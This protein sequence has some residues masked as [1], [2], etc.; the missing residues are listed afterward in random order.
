MRE[1]EPPFRVYACM[2][3]YDSKLE[4]PI[5][6]PK[7]I[8]DI[9]PEVSGQCRSHAVPLAETENTAHVTYFFNGGR[10]EPF[11]GEE[12]TMIPSP[13]DVATY[14][15]KPDGHSRRRGRGREGDRVRRL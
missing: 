10:E 7:E 14:D 2:T 1:A 13:K 4:L 8:S 9:F 15:L 6:F 5:A 3:T 11:P 12:R